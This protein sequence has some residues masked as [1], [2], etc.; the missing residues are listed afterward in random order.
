[1]R[2]KQPTQAEEPERAVGHPAWL[3]TARAHACVCA[4]ASASWLGERRPFPLRC[5]LP[6]CAPCSPWPVLRTVAPVF[7]H[8]LF[9]LSRSDHAPPHRRGKARCLPH[10][11]SVGW[12]PPLYPK[13]PGLLSQHLPLCPGIACL[14]PCPLLDCSL[15]RAGLVGLVPVVCP[16]PSLLCGW[17]TV[18]A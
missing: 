14:S 18:G 3:D 17:H 7:P 8:F 9:L 6:S 5:R 12:A 4:S 13:A 10:I 15:L 1:M 16:G 11:L 2:L